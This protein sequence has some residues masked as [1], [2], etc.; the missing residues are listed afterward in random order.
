MWGKE[1]QGNIK[2]NTS[3]IVCPPTYLTMP[4]IQ[5]ELKWVG[6]CFSCTLSYWHV[7]WAIQ[8][9]GFDLGHN[10]V[11]ELRKCIKIWL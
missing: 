7:P 3:S 2:E 1:S 4:S 5:R 9:S 11:R 6:V 8:Q 10:N